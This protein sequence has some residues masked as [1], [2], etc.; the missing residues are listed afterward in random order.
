VKSPESELI[1]TITSREAYD[2]FRPLLKDYVTLPEAWIVVEDI[3]AWFEANPSAG[4]LD[5]PAFLAWS[6]VNQHSVWKPDKWS[7][8]EAIVTTARAIP[9]P[10]GAIVE[11]FRELDAAAQIRAKADAAITKGDTGALDEIR[12]ILDAYQVA[13]ANPSSSDLVSDD[14]QVLLDT[15]V[16]SG[17]V[18]WRLEDL[19]VATGPLHRGDLVM[20]GARPEV[21]KTTFLC[22]EITHMVTQL[23]EGKNAL[24]VNNEERGEKIKLRLVQAA[25]GLTLNEIIGDPQVHSATYRAVLAGRRIDVASRPTI[26]TTDIER[27]CRKGDY[28]IVGLNILDKLW[29]FPELEGVERSRRLA[30]W[31][32][33]L[34]D[35]YGVV[36]ALS[37]A[38]ASAEGQRTLDQSQLYGSKT[39]VQGEADVLLMIGKENMPQ[40]AERRW[41][42][43]CKNKMPHGPRVNEAVSHGQF[44]VAIDALRARYNTLAQKGTRP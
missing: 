32:R 20:I 33:E 21:G 26:S 6:K 18:E 38:D 11:R 28:G 42:N 4:E 36:F 31:A 7:V 22:S 39:G 12:P 35:K 25:L 17:G 43:V 5:W 40:F 19:N 9:Q 2:S 27:L 15:T 44:E 29:G 3:G 24:I 37:Q 8:Y 14:L 41:I 1:R 23:P 30:I 10:N 34:A 13:S 16:R